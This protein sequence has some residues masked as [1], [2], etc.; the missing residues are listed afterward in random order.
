LEFAANY[1]AASLV[2]YTVGSL[3]KFFI[4]TRPLFQL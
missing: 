4:S 1:L 3:D 2:S